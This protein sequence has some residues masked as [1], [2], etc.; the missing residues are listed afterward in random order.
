[1]SKFKV[2]NIDGSNWVTEE[3]RL[4]DNR[5]NILFYH[6]ALQCAERICSNIIAYS[7][8]SNITRNNGCKS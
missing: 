3:E 5:S 2:G 7:G 6:T 4:R 1:M 8:T